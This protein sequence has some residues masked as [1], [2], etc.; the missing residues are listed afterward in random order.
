MGE[1][2]CIKYNYTLYSYFNKKES[3]SVA[4]WNYRA[5]SLLAT[6]NFTMAHSCLLSLH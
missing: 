4:E 2:I 6:G 5:P 1:N 3:D